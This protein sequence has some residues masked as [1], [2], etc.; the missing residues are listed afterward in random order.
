MTAPARGW[1]WPA[2]PLPE[3]V[4]AERRWAIWLMLG[5]AIDNAAGDA[6]RAAR[7]NALRAAVNRE[8]MRYWRMLM[9]VAIAARRREDEAPVRGL[10]PIRSDV[11]QGLNQTAFPAPRPR[12]LDFIATVT[13]TEDAER[14]PAKVETAFVA[15]QTEPGAA[16]TLED[17]AALWERP[18]R[19]ALIRLR[20]SNA[21]NIMAALQPL[22]EVGGEPLQP[23]IGIL[24]LLSPMPRSISQA[25]ARAHADL[26]DLLDR[27]TAEMLFGPRRRLVIQALHGLAQPKDDNVKRSG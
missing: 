21:T 17:L 11:P 26:P 1:A 8:T 2:A 6:P 13:L 24:V 23:R 18:H 19:A 14:N 27:L 16:D 22:V 15:L 9:T 10:P 12:L 20:W 4:G 3:S 25:F 5:A 7:L